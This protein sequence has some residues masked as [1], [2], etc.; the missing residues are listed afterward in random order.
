MRQN[1]G[2]LLDGG[3][4]ND[5]RNEFRIYDQD[6]LLQKS[7]FWRFSSYDM[8]THLQNFNEVVAQEYQ[9]ELKEFAQEFL[10]FCN[11]NSECFQNGYIQEIFNKKK[12]SLESIVQKIQENAPCSFD[13]SA[14][15]NDVSPFQIHSCSSIFDNFPS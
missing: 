9:I 4:K 5:R 6:K 8:S 3:P 11:D 12:D 2:K 13:I 15:L 7:E 1:F 10:N 14:Q